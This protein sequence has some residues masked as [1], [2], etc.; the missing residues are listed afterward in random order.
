[1]DTAFA[2]VE[3]EEGNAPGDNGQQVTPV[4]FHG[5]LLARLLNQHM[6]ASENE[7]KRAEHGVENSL[8]DVRQQQH[9][10]HLDEQGEVLQGHWREIKQGLENAGFLAQ[11]QMCA[12]AQNI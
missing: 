3:E 2:D 6:F 10:A 11:E 12:C 4:N 8:T 9:E 5:V 7:P 1:M